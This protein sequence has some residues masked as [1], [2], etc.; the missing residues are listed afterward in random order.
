MKTNINPTSVS[1]RR[2]RWQTSSLLVPVFF[3]FYLTASIGARAGDSI[4]KAGDVLQF[5]LP[6]TAAGLTL[7]YW[8]GKGALEFGESAALT[9][10]VTYGLKYTVNE[11]RPNG[12]S[13]SFPSAHTSISFCSAEFMRKRYGWEYGIP[14]YAAASFVAYS[15]VEAGE[16]HPHDV[17]A[18]AVI[19][20]VSSY[21]FTKPYKGW[22]VQVDADDKYFRINLCHAL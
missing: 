3:S 1:K 18:G 6:G 20:I 17:V 5:V 13:Q 19:G 7:G 15:R 2:R 9:L 16:H 14:A 21:I 11:K 22:H 8:D 4:A 10:G 12:G